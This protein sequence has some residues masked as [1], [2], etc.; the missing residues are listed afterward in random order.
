MKR[1]K[2]WVAALGGAGIF[3]GGALG[4]GL[5]TTPAGAQGDEGPKTECGQH[6]SENDLGMYLS[7]SVAWTDELTKEDAREAIRDFMQRSNITKL[8]KV[9]PA[10]FTK[11]S[12]TPAQNGEPHVVAYAYDRDGVRLAYVEASNPGDGWRVD[13]L[14]ICQALL[15]EQQ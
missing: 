2:L 7:Q 9:S 1:T 14:L 13:D 4:G 10:G 12:E 8:Q 6:E 5:A 11:V 3:V 15:D